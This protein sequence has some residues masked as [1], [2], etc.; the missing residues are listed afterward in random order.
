MQQAGPMGRLILAWQNTPMQM[1][2]LT[3]KALSDL[4]KRRRTPGY[5]Q[6]QSDMGNI[7]SI[8][9]YG[10][11]QNLIF[12]ALQTGLMFL[13]FGWD[14][15]EERKKKLEL[16][17]LNGALDTLLRGT[18]I[19]G[20]AVSTLKN[21]LLKWKEERE[22]PAWKRDDWNIAQEAINLSPPI[23]SKMRKLMGAIR[24]E[25][26][27]PGVSK[28]IGFRIENPNLSIA[29]NW[30]EAL[31][32]IPVARV[33]SKTNNVEEA[34]NSNNDIWQRVALVSGW[35]R[36]SVGVEDEELKAAKEK[37]KEKKKKEKDKGKVRCTAIKKSG[38]RCKNTTRNKN[39]KCYA[40]Q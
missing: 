37:V 34:L 8:I 18:G 3:K 33:V 30:T 22:G 15:D 10:I 4:V 36:W 29:A 31:L 17:T 32:N 40:H 6:I 27:N 19:Y 21:V 39:K 35:S 25:K 38:G 11:A 12:G 5:N 24:T 16:R 23:G 28:E 14:E 13:L 1:T 9:Y 26:Y 20:A 2:R 7:S